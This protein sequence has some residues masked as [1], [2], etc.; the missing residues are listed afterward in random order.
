MSKVDLI[1]VMFECVT[2]SQLI[3]FASLCNGVLFDVGTLEVTDIES[4][5]SPFSLC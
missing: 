4:T 1:I 5:A 2:E 3:V